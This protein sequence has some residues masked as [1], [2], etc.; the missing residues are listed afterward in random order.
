M[1]LE[2]MIFIFYISFISAWTTSCPFSQVVLDGSKDNIV[3]SRRSGCSDVPVGERSEVKVGNV[4]T[5][6]DKGPS[7]YQRYRKSNGFGCTPPALGVRK[8]PVSSGAIYVFSGL[9]RKA[10]HNFRCSKMQP[11]HNQTRTGP[12]RRRRIP[13]TRAQQACLSCRAKKLKVGSVE[14][15]AFAYSFAD[16]K[17]RFQCDDT[18]PVCSACS[19]LGTRT[20]SQNWRTHLKKYFGL[21]SEQNALRKILEPGQSDRGTICKH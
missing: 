20:I 9:Q 6:K 21:T 11:S 19:R 12:A 15:S 13:G 7:R 1:R 3:Y 5:V 16:D 18:V 10:I 8:L 17:L 14:E 2:V 4:E